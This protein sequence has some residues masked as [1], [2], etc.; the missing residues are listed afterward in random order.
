MPLDAGTAWLFH[1]QNM[2]DAPVMADWKKIL[3]DLNEQAKAEY[4]VGLSVDESAAIKGLL[5]N[6]ILAKQ[7]P[8][9]FMQELLG[10]VVSSRGAGL[11]CRCRARKARMEE[12]DLPHR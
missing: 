4:G 10:G 8:E 2:W 6:A 12:L 11:P 5:H 7:T 9:Q 3:V 1:M